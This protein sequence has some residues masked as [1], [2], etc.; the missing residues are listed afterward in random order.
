ML[1]TTKPTKV[2]TD[3]PRVINFPLTI[4]ESAAILSALTI[5]S[6]SG[7]SGVEFSLPRR[8]DGSF[9]QIAT[10]GVNTIR[11]IEIKLLSPPDKTGEFVTGKQV[12]TWAFD[13]IA[14]FEYAADP[15][16]QL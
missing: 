1:R 5:L 8:E 15:A 9:C 10:R 6:D 7:A 3:R 12:T 13:N 4:L 2:N 16:N 14:D 11:T